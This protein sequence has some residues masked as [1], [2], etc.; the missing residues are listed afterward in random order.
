MAN[1]FAIVLLPSRQH[2]CRR[3]VTALCIYNVTIWT[4]ER[5]PS[6]MKQLIVIDL[7]RDQ[8]TEYAESHIIIKMNYN[9]TQ[10]KIDVGPTKSN[11]P[12]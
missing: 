5:A 11:A 9:Y 4:N 2:C 8:H 7:F 12:R 6:I 1:H 3:F 10:Y